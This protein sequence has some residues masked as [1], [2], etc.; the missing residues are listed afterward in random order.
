MINQSTSK[1]YTP[2]NTQATR[3]AP[4][5]ARINREGEWETPA[6]INRDGEW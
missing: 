4:K 1:A 6:H 5:E 2:Q 3:P